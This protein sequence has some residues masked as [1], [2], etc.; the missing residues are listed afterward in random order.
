[1]AD[2]QV[3]VHEVDYLATTNAKIDDAPVVVITIRPEPP[4]FRPH[5]L[6]I[7]RSQA[8]RLFEDLKTVLSR[9]AVW[10]S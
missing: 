4:A 5:N 9:S 6:A 7:A 1:M 3:R 8:E 10:P 2:H